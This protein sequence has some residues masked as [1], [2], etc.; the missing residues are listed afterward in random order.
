MLFEQDCT[1]DSNKGNYN[2]WFI[3]KIDLNNFNNANRATFPAEAAYFGDRSGD[4]TGYAIDVD[5]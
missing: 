1:G 4:V 5:D 3:M 2:N